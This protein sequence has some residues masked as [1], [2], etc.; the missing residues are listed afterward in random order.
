[1]KEKQV[2]RYVS[3]VNDNLSSPGYS[4]D[5]LLDA[6]AK[7]LKAKNDAQ[8][9]KALYVEPAMVCK[10]RRRRAELSAALLV[11]M[12]DVTGMAINEL[13]ALANIKPAVMA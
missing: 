5:R 1:M 10:L 7:R 11:R 8:L 6:L 13:R 9:A 12:H 3:L 4:P 2:K